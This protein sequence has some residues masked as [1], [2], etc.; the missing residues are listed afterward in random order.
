MATVPYFVFSPNVVLSLIG[1]LHGPDKTVPTELEDWHDA[2]V[3][4]VI[5]AYNEAKNIIYCLQSLA[6]QTFKP[7]R[8]IVIDD[9]STD[10]TAELARIFGNDFGLNI[11]VISRAESIGKTPTLKRQAREYDGDVEFILDADTV[12]ESDDYIARTIEELYKGNGIA[13]ACGIILPERP[14]DRKK[15]WECPAV[16]KFHD[17]HPE[18]NFYDHRKP[19]HFWSWSLTNSYRKILYLFLQRFL[20]HGQMVFF[21]G[22]VNPV[23][24]AVAYRRKYLEALFEH[25]EPLLGDNLTNS[26]DVF[27]G[28][29]FN[30]YGYHNVQVMDVYARSE[31]P[32]AHRLPQQI[33][34]WSSAFLQSSYYFD[35]L[36]KTPFKL[37]KL[38]KKRRDEK[39]SGVAEKHEH[40]RKIKEQYRQAFGREYTQDFGRPIGWTIFMSTLEKIAFPALIIIMIAFQAWFPLSLTLLL[41]TLL[42]SIILVI[43]SEKEKVKN[44]FLAFLVT[45]VRYLLLFADIFVIARF[46]VDIWLRKETTWRK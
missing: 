25:Y 34:L 27:I 21:G 2:K 17:K 5:P 44:F 29:A 10:N 40:Q 22:I 14:I 33:Q 4:V 32:E 45:P 8:I 28:F 46:A 26:E 16:Q 23:G 11:E 13:C 12:L 36:S 37:F 18:L 1:L 31:E 19:W 15:E 7:Y 24:C 30:D 38:L 42:S 6:R 9:G 35:A 20:Y 3:N 41:E 43:I 39:R